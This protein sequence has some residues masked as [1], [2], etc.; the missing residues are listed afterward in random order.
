MAIDDI[1]S[2][3]PRGLRIN[4]HSKSFLRETAKWAKFLSIVGFVGIGLMVLLAVFGEYLS[5]NAANSNT[6]TFE[7]D[8]GIAGMVVVLIL[9]I[10]YFFPVYYL[11]KF[12]NNMKA[13][14]QSEEEDQLTDA[15]EMLKSHYKFMGILTIIILS[16]YLLLFFI[17]FMAALSV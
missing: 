16:I 17:G 11:Y 10:I 4:E 8:G 14:L 15:F 12:A 3:T 6:F 1:G 7:T 5:L 2:N 13:A 9:A